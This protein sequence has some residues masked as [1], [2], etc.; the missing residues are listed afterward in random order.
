[1]KKKRVNPPKRTRHTV[2]R[3]ARNDGTLNER[4]RE[5]IYI[6]GNAFSSK[7]MVGARRE[8]HHSR[9]RRRRRR[10][11]FR[12]VRLARVGVVVA[13]AGVPARRGRGNVGRFGERETVLADVERGVWRRR[14]RGTIFGK[15][16][17]IEGTPPGRKDIGDGWV[18]LET[19]KA[20]VSRVVIVCSEFAGIV[21]NGGIGTFYTSLANVLSS[22]EEEEEEG[23]SVTFNV[24]LL[25]T[26]TESA[27]EDCP[28]ACEKQRN[29]DKC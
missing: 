22:E 24:T 18:S 17:E 5:Q 26:R 10:H 25:Y 28:R 23:T 3:D 8:K 21:P 4:E 15:R 13:D 11:P 6:F 2:S 7:T 9:R 29:E 16:K 20:R 12:R 1:M 19:T 14:T 27:R